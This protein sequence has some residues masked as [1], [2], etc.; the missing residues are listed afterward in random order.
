MR[1]HNS[2]GTSYHTMQCLPMLYTALLSSTRML[3]RYGT[4]TSQNLMFLGE[5]SSVIL[6]HASFLLHH[7]AHIAANSGPTPRNLKLPLIKIHTFWKVGA[8]LSHHHR[9]V[10]R[11]PC[12]SFHHCHHSHRRLVR[13]VNG[14]RP[15]C[16]QLPAGMSQVNDMRNV[17]IALGQTNSVWHCSLLGCAQQSFT[18]HLPCTTLHR[19]QWEREW[20]CSPDFADA[21]C[22]K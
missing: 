14:C 18:L 4:Q 19:N 16:R 17:N 12:R 3:S 11:C 5:S 10:R 8:H 15:T 20:A 7:T 9:P 21:M 1:S 2:K 6:A 13:W 22:K